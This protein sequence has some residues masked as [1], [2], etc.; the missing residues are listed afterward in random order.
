MKT[1]FLLLLGIFL[2]VSV[3]SQ[4]PIYS[5]SIDFETNRNLAV[6]DTVQVSNC[7]QIGTPSKILFDSAVSAPFAILTDS[8]HPYPVNNLSSFEVKILSHG[9]T[10]W[11][12]GWMR[13]L[14]KYDFEPGKDGGF[15]E[16]RYDAD[17]NWTNII[18][19]TDPEIYANGINFYSSTDTISGNIPAFTGISD[20][21]VESQFQ[22]AWEIGVK[23][24]FHDSLTIRFSMKSDSF[25]TNQEGW[26]IDNLFLELHGCTGSIEDPDLGTRSSE[27]SPN[28]VKDRSFLIFKNESGKEAIAFFYDM[29]G[30]IMKKVVTCSDKIS[31][32]NSDFQDGIYTYKI[33]TDGSVTGSG[34]FIVQH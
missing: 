27:I 3:Q 1:F 26:M 22:W 28:P 21:W 33:F 19:D 25:Q 2:C 6:I 9:D 18:L 14:H 12:I 34:K 23:S 31:L 11:G 30:K 4:S 5:A 29:N 32:T 7:W 13:F 10:C 15:I 24:F 8:V 17:T 16:V 20:G